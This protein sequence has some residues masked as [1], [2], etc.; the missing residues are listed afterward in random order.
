[1]IKA[2]IFDF[3]GVIQGDPY[4]IWLSRNKLSRSGEYSQLARQVDKGEIDRPKFLEGLSKTIGREVTAEE[5]YGN[6]PSIDIE[7]IELIAKLKIKYQIGLL[8]NASATL[9]VKLDSMGLATLFDDITASSE[10]GFAKPET[11]IFK[12]SLDNLG[13]EASQAIFIDDSLNN[14]EAAEL[15]GIKSIHYKDPASLKDTMRKLG[16][17]I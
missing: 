3:Y 13:V 5:L 4:N 15:L 10:T 12:I 7:I 11:E 17:E 6:I 14:I 16:L 1:M 2:I 9:R 8:S